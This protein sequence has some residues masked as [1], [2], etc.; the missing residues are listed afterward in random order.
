MKHLVVIG[1]GVAGVSVALEGLEP[2]S[3]AHVTLIEK[4]DSLGGPAYSSHTNAGNYKTNLP[5][6]AMWVRKQ[7][8]HNRNPHV[9]P[10]R[11]ISRKIIGRY[12]EGRFNHAAK[13]AYLP[14]YGRVNGSRISG[15]AVDIMFYNGKPVVVMDDGRYIHADDVVVA[16]GFAARRPLPAITSEELHSPRFRKR[17]I[18][19]P[20]SHGA[21]L[22]FI[23]L[24]K[25]A[26]VAILGT[27]LSA[28]DAV[29]RLMER[30]HKGPITM[31]STNGLEHPQSP[32]D[33]FQE[34][35][36][37]PIPRFIRDIRQHGVWTRYTT[38][39]M[40]EEFSSLTGMPSYLAG[41][42][43][44]V[45]TNP[46]PSCGFRGFSLYSSEQVLRG[47]EKYIPEVIR[48][49]GLRQAAALLKQ[50]SSL[51][52]VLRIGAG[53]DAAEIVKKA[54]SRGQ[55]TVESGKISFIRA[56]GSGVEINYKP[57]DYALNRSIHAHTI[58]STLGPD[59]DY[60]RTR[61]PLWRNLIARGYTTP[62]D[63][64]V[65]IDIVVSGPEFGRLPHV[66]HIFAAG[67]CAA[68]AYMVT[69][70]RIGPPAFS[71]PGMRANI[72]KTAHAALTA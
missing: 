28:Y 66:K 62:H 50:Y 35:V 9:T 29:R 59:H 49:I 54:K 16:T 57:N 37:L 47:W 24:P 27:G 3:R 67:V 8:E 36:E 38:Q 53:H 48:H 41:N 39:L 32:L 19:D 42:R 61:D 71:V 1:G 56:T 68:G 10:T 44:S 4:E 63:I 30:K 46:S 7:Y 17:F 5:A 55:L 70:G 20:F 34:A 26:P 21:E 45:D 43:L 33:N 6:S 11:V 51:I 60:S 12:L 25:N 23:Q 64:G 58:I 13:N 15:T 69:D 72:M 22:Q 31:I 40:L 18:E 14:R 65:G 2:P 52:N